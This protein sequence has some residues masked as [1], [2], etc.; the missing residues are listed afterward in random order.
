MEAFY[1]FKK[2]SCNPFEVTSKLWAPFNHWSW[3][4]VGTLLE[5]VQVVAPK[6]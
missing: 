3:E 1:P 2:N 5:I 6:D 4:L